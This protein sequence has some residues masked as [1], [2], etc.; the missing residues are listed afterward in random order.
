[1]HAMKTWH[2]IGGIT[3]LALIAFGYYAISPLFRNV[4][5]DEALP[6][7]RQMEEKLRNSHFLKRLLRQ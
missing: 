6:E 2:I 1:M 7:T 4:K 3:L 5:V